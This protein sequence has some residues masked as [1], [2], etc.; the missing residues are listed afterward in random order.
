VLF[1]QLNCSLLIALFESYSSN[2]RK[3]ASSIKFRKFSIDSQGFMIYIQERRFY[4]KLFNKRA[5]YIIDSN[6]MKDS[7]YLL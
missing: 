6:K 7:I 3:I 1:V 5:L 2:N 4:I